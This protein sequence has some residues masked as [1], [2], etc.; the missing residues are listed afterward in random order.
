MPSLN[1][2]DKLLLIRCP[3]CGQRFKVGDDLRGRTV[4]CGGCEHRFKIN[5]DVIVRGQ[6]FYPGERRDTALNRFQRV[7]LAMIPEPSGIATTRYIEPPDATEFEPIAPQRIIAGA[8]GGCVMVLV[9]LLL[10]F[11]ASHGGALDMWTTQQ[12]VVLAGFTGLLGTMLLVYANPRGRFKSGGYGLLLSVGLLALPFFFTEGSSDTLQTKGTSVKKDR[13]SARSESRASGKKADPARAESEAII[14]LRALIGTDPL[15]K[16]IVEL[17]K[18]NAGKPEKEQKHAVGLWVKGLQEVNRYVV[19]DYILRETGAN[20]SMVFYPRGNDF[21]IVVAGITKTLDEVAGLMSALGTLDKVHREISVLEV[22]INNESFVA[23]SL[24]KLTDKRGAEFY[25]LNKKELE[26]I[27]LDRVQRA[28]RRL[29]EVEPTVFRSDISSRLL[30]LLEAPGGSVT[31][32][33][34][35]CRALMV[36]SMEPELAGTAA[37]HEVRSLLDHKT[38]VPP[39]MMKLIV[40]EKIPEVIPV[41]DELW[42]GGATRWES[43][44]AEVGPPAEALLLRRFPETNGMLRQSAVRLLGLVG[45]KDSLP[46]LE[47][48]AKNADPE[49]KVLLE[50]STA[51]IRQ[52]LKP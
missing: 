10:I 7:P 1:P 47:A 33:G 37:L 46:V 51:S 21:L 9:A 2:D 39:E 16:E 23:G 25:M 12:R 13:D 3:S 26:S 31:L 22:T 4:E 5:D 35:I 30:S 19:R 38:A 45:G 43:I 42:A 29:A 18:A 14:R 8:I 28:V 50:K 48:T 40:K 15:E 49:L 24:E 52:R 32:K 11:G 41:L 17:A 36:W 6:K 44:Y 20:Q 27:D 34:D